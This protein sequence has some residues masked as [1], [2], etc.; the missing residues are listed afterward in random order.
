MVI[1]QQFFLIHMAVVSVSF[2]GVDF[3][4][5]RSCRGIPDSC[6]LRVEVVS[7]LNQ[8]RKLPFEECVNSFISIVLSR[9]FVLNHPIDRASMLLG[10]DYIVI[11]Q[12]K[13]IHYLFFIFAL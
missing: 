11:V 8:G 3:L 9:V 10:V 1:R 12:S 4:R 2:S 5:R 6:L 13:L 7:T